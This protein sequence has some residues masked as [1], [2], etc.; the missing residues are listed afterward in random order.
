[1]F[2]PK[3]LFVETTGSVP[4]NEWMLKV[5]AGVKDGTLEPTASGIWSNDNIE[6]LD[7]EHVELISGYQRYFVQ[8]VD[9]VGEVSID[10]FNEKYAPLTR[11]NFGSGKVVKQKP[12]VTKE[13]LED[14]TVAE[15]KQFVNAGTKALQDAV[16]TSGKKAEMIAEILIFFN[17]GI[18]D[19]MLQMDN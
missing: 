19:E 5:L 18:V 9:V 3:S 13:K 4:S 7:P 2:R 12:T 14:L 6:I 1:M 11:E 15:I 10:N 17:V 8:G 16:H